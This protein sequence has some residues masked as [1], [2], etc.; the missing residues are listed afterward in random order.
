MAPRIMIPV[1]RMRIAPQTGQSCQ[2]SI[3]PALIQPGN[4][5][6]IRGEAS[7]S[8][9]LTAIAAIIA[10][11]YQRKTTCSLVFKNC[12]CVASEYRTHTMPA[13]NAAP[14]NRTSTAPHPL[15]YSLS[16]NEPFILI[17][18]GNR[19]HARGETSMKA[20][21]TASTRARTRTASQPII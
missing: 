4:R 6:Q 3:P 17:Q 19:N 14:A 2:L 7:I 8:R 12:S 1:A 16:D 20:A 10:T 5:A 13:R 11:T 9:P 18:S 15:V 21:F